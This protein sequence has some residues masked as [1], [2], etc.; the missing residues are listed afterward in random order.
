M[1]AVLFV[2]CTLQQI[3]VLARRATLSN[4]E[5]YFSET[6]IIFSSSRYLLKSEVSKKKIVEL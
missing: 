1:E 3:D 4:G 5:D 6:K 2:V